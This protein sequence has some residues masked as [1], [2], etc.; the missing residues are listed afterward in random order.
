[1]KLIETCRIRNGK[2]ELKQKSV[3]VSDI[4][5]FKDGDY[6]ITIEKAKKK[7][8]LEQNRYYHGVIVP[9]VKEWLIDA[10]WRVTTSQVH[11]YLKENFNIIE[12]T[13]EVSGE[14]LKTIGSTS[15]MT[16]SQMMDYF[17]K[18]TQWAA[19]YLNVQIPAPNEQLTIETV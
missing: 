9:L 5:K 8:S 6:V 13:N 18:I 1:M 14:I 7:R 3:F 2:L 10:G 12:I 19:E 4:S 15:E 17:A 16:T 11:E